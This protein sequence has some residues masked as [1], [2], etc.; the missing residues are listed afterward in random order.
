MAT[1]FIRATLAGQMV[2]VGLALGC[3]GTSATK[4]NENLTLVRDGAPAASI[5]TAR[6]PTPSARLAAL[7]IQF[8]LMRITGAELPI[9]TDAENV[10]GTRIL[11]GDSD[12]ALKLGFKGMDFAPQEYLVA[13]RPDCVILIGRDW[14][15]TEANRKEQGR[16][17]TDESLQDLRHR[18]DYWKAVGLPDRSAGE[19]ELPGIHDDQGT[20]YAAYDFLERVCG[21]RWYGPSDINIVFPDKKTLQV[22]GADVRRSPALKHRSALAGGSWPFMR[23]QWGDYTRDQVCLYWRRMKM[24]GE[25]WAGNHTIHRSTIQNVLNDPEYQAQNPAGKGSQLCYTNEKL[26]A[27]V[28]QMARDYFDGK[29][30]LPVGWK[31]MGDYFAIVP[32]DNRNLC[33][34]RKCGE[35]QHLGIG[36][37]TGH[38]S[39]GEIS[40][41]WFSFVNAVARE[42]RKTHPDKYIATLAYWCYAVHPRSIEVEPNVSIAPCL[43]L[44][45]YAINDSMRENDLALYNAWREKSPAPMFMWV[46][47]HHPME[48]ALIQQWKC[49]PDFMPHVSAQYMRMFIK[50]GVRGIFRCGEPDQLEHHVM[51]KVWDDPTLDTDALMNEFFDLYF[52]AAAEP[53]RKFY[54]RIEETVTNPANYPPKKKG[55]DEA[56]SWDNLGT[57]QRMDELGALI[58][59]AETLAKSDIEKKRVALWRKAVWQWMLDG[60][61][62]YLAKGGRK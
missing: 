35:L 11:V 33:L 4:Q 32:D 52:G 20:C 16:T 57:A 36:M 58:A 5:I 43:H 1:N 61:A 26:V 28:A 14:Q 54:A 18:I 38:F 30:E 8:H 19:M 46:Y 29:G 60:R 3:A 12:A 51:V 15:D 23:G 31:A 39:S 45:Y 47:Y 50:D 22:A 37:A 62:E 53:M 13:F 17:T 9:R 44:C 56:I 2:I 41:Y 6:N 7:E 27:R 59:E 24:G 40:D 49:F 34:C 21:V 42:V 25:R 10:S 48:M 55:W